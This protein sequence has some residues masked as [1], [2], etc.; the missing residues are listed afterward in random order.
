MSEHN[1]QV[2]LNKD[3]MLQ[4]KLTQLLEYGKTKKRIPS[5][6]LIEL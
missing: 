2:E 3:E 5:K 1:A 6:M 4:K